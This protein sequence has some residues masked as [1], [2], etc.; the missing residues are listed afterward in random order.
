[1]W[2]C[3]GGEQAAPT[4]KLRHNLQMRG[5]S[6]TGGIACW[7]QMGACSFPFAG[8]SPGGSTRSLEG[9][10]A[11][12]KSGEGKGFAIALQVQRSGVD[13]RCIYYNVRHCWHW[14]LTLL[15]A[16]KPQCLQSSSWVLHCSLQRLNTLCRANVQSSGF[17]QTLSHSPSPCPP[18][19]TSY[20]PPSTPWWWMIGT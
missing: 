4:C 11:A 13:M 5:P 15:E 6:A 2:M 12:S 9:H 20:T 18:L 10:R 3:W 16:S 1:M 17:H 14:S 7:V 8:C 19:M